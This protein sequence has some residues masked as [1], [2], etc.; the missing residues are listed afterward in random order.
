MNAPLTSETFRTILRTFSEDCSFMSL[1]HMWRKKPEF[2]ELLAWAQKNKPSSLTIL[3]EEI[4]ACGWQA[5]DLIHAL[6]G[7]KHE[8][9]SETFSMQNN[10]DQKVLR[11]Y[12]FAMRQGYNT[13]KIFTAYS[14]L[15]QKLKVEREMERVI[16]DLD[17]RRANRTWKNL[18]WIRVRKKFMRIAKKYPARF[19]DCA[20]NH[21]LLLRG[22]RSVEPDA[23][24]VQLLSDVMA[25]IIPAPPKL[26][27]AKTPA[28][29]YYAWFR[30]NSHDD[31]GNYTGFTKN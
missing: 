19:F 21:H 15:H 22:F 13:P 6:L 8:V 14:I 24:L 29:I 17:Y 20:L 1:S 27:R 7:E 30:R 23:E 3:F 2:A 12:R 31:E 5:L 4:E 28:E 18:D 16:A 9:L 25:T 10:Y 11:L 26:A